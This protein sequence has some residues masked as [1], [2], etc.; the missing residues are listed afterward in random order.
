MLYMTDREKTIH[1]TINT[2]A[3]NPATEIVKII[4]DIENKDI[5]DLPIIY[6]YVGDVLDNIFSN[7]PKTESKLS[8]TFNYSS[9]KVTFKQNGDLE[10]EIIN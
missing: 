2:D 7:P 8:V 9:Y 5:T 1:R 3:D 6:D 10:L 4:S